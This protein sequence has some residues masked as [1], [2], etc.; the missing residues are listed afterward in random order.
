M[1]E[2]ADDRFVCIVVVCEGK[3]ILEGKEAFECEA[4]ENILRAFERFHRIL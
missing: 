2:S 1:K 4:R 3:K